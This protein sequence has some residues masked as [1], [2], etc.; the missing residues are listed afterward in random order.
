V[1]WDPVGVVVLTPTG[2]S[3]PVALAVH[4]AGGGASARGA[5]GRAAGAEHRVAEGSGGT[6]H[7]PVPGGFTSPTGRRHCRPKGAPEPILPL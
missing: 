7:D 5:G 2:S 6:V 4:P 3:V 1:N